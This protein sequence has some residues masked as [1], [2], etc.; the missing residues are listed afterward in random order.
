MQVTETKTEGLTREF[1][2]LV[3]AAT[4]EEKVTV[5]LAEIGKTASLPG[6][7]PRNNFV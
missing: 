1:S 4:I 6:F 5:R 7:R 2:I 3:P